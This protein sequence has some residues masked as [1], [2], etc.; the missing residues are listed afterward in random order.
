ML[1]F[2]DRQSD[3]IPSR[4]KQFGPC[5]LVAHEIHAD[6]RAALKRKKELHKQFDTFKRPETEIFLLNPMEVL[7]VRIAMNRT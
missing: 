4:I 3:S 5:E 1:L 7:R 2:Q 6:S